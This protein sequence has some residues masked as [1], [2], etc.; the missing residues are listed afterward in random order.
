MKG[1]SKRSRV[2]WQ[3][4]SWRLQVVSLAL[5]DGTTAEKGVIEH[6]GSVVIVPMQES[7]V[8]MLRQYR[9]ALGEMIL[10]L[11]AG[12]R[13]WNEDWLDCAQRELREETGHRAQDWIPLG[14]VWP[15]PGL[16]DELMAIYL[17]T[18]LTLA[19]L[20]ADPDEQIEVE[21]IPL[22]ELLAMAID[23]RLRDAKSVVGIIRTAAHLGLLR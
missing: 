21:P 16:T 8:L 12:T 1:N 13:G 6:P 4:D 7:Q 9:L 19:P 23:G 11:P 2:E 5:P 14:R 18:E 20:P 3:G 22:D 15:A 17:A 10:E